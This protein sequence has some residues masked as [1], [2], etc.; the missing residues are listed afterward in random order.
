MRGVSDLSGEISR[1]FGAKLAAERSKAGLTQEELGYRC[2]LSPAHVARLE[3]GE[4]DVRLSSFMRLAGGL[5]IEPADLL[6]SE[7]WVPP[8]PAK[9]G[10]FSAG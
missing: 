3:T 1:R 9:G 5:G 8:A 7:R 10:E 4:V 2:E 6:P